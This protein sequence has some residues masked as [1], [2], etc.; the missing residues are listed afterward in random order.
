MDVLILNHNGNILRVQ[1]ALVTKTT[2]KFPLAHTQIKK[3][4]NLYFPFEP[5]Q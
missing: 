4:K 5:F 3:N 1:Q 2:R